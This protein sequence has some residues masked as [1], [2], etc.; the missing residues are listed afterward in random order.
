MDQK[1]QYN[2]TGESSR[3]SKKQETRKKHND[4]KT[5]SWDPLYMKHEN[6]II[7][8]H[9]SFENHALLPS[10]ARLIWLSHKT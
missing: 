1:L 3:L 8:N 2:P 6:N 10:Q 4:D 9:R 7:D 5:I